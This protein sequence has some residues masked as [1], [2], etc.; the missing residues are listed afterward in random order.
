MI[1]RQNRL[2]LGHHPKVR[3][4]EE[5]RRGLEGIEMPPGSWGKAGPFGS[6]LLVANFRWNDPKTFTEAGAEIG[7]ISEA[8]LECYF[9]N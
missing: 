3:R 7:R 6:R 2:K 8:N 5:N 9:R 1:P 4:T